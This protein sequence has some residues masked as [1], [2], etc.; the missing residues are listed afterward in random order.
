MLSATLSRSLMAVLATPSLSLSFTA[1]SSGLTG[2]S[3]YSPRISPSCSRSVSAALNICS[4]WS[5][6]VMPKL[7]RSS[8]VTSL[9]I[10]K[11]WYPCSMK[12][13]K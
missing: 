2:T 6:L 10:S 8:F 12:T 5:S 3:R 4:W 1:G 7:S 13:F 9:N 11:S